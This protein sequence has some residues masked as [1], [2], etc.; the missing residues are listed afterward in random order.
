[1][2][3]SKKHDW[4]RAHNGELRCKRCMTYFM[5]GSQMGT[6][7]GDPLEHTRTVSRR[8]CEAIVASLIDEEH[9]CQKFA[10]N[11]VINFMLPKDKD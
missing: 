11:I 7:H 5:V 6:V 2:T 9:P 1:M 10:E 8:L 4:E 3:Q